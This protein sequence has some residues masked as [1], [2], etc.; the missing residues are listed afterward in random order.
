LN[1]PKF[2]PPTNT[3]GCAG[4]DEEEGGGQPAAS[5]RGRRWKHREYQW[6]VVSKSWRQGS[7]ALYDI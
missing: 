2:T 5:G 3:R 1:A 7:R 4:G 6:M